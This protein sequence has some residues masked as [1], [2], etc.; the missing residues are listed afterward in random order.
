[1]GISKVSERRIHLVCLLSL[2]VCVQGA[3]VYHIPFQVSCYFYKLIE[4]LPFYHGK[5]RPCF[6][7]CAYS[8]LHA[9]GRNSVGLCHIILKILILNKRFN[10]VY[11]AVMQGIM[12]IISCYERSGEIVLIRSSRSRRRSDSWLG[13][14]ERQRLDYPR[15]NQYSVR[16]IQKFKSFNISISKC[17]NPPILLVC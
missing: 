9:H 11:D 16:T 2:C 15:P 12:L 1:M 6:P 10:K 5:V 14:G 4:P 7:F 3:C 17:I 13:V 8:H